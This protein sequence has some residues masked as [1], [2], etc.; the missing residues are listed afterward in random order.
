MSCF[1]FNYLWWNLPSW[2]KNW[3]VFQVFL[4]MDII[5]EKLK[6]ECMCFGVFLLRFWNISLLFIS[7]VRITLNMNMNSRKREY[8]ELIWMIRNHSYKHSDSK[9]HFSK[10]D[11][12]AFWQ[13][14]LRENLKHIFQWSKSLFIFSRK[15]FLNDV[16]WQTWLH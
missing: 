15:T 3:L 5:I 12:N 13:T 6:V 2:S 8:P 10:S 9:K 16:S 1:L 14:R 4:K 7:I 11:Q